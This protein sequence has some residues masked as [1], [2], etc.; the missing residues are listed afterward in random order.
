M[1][2]GGRGGK[3]ASFHE[4][5]ALPK[6]TSIAGRG[7]IV[8][9]G[10]PAGGPIKP[11]SCLCLVAPPCS[12]YLGSVVWGREPGAQQAPDQFLM[13]SQRSEQSGV[14]RPC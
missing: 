5:W 3:G 8:E 4:C 1:V 11:T 7:R 12:P 14:G 6:S 13:N 2:H 9:T 10:L